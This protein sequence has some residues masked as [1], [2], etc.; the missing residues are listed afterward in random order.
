MSTAIVM[1]M[2]IQIELFEN[3]LTHNCNNIYCFCL[4]GAGGGAAG[5][6]GGGAAT[7]LCFDYSTLLSLQKFL[8]SKITCRLTR[9]LLDF[10]STFTRLLLDFALATKVSSEQ[11]HLSTCRLDFYST[12]LWLLD[13]YS[14]L[15]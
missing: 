13:F 4:G 15:L 14:T 2:N 8:L 7:R 3:H 10:H 11:I 12:L 5:G 9:L 6:A 1:K